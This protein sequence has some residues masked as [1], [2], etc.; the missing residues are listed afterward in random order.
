MMKTRWYHVTFDIRL[1]KCKII[2]TKWYLFLSSRS[3]LTLLPKLFGSPLEPVCGRLITQSMALPSRQK[4][5]PLPLLPNKKKNRWFPK[6]T[7]AV[8]TPETKIWLNQ[9]M[10]ILKKIKSPIYWSWRWSLYFFP[11][12]GMQ[13]VC[14]ISL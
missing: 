10:L 1:R 8:S 12:L 11:Y 3:R 5:V 6:S 14:K 4:K 9:N 7:I 13:V 2:C